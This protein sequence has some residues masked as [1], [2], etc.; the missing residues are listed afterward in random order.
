M[1]ITIEDDPVRVVTLCVSGHATSGEMTA[2]QR[3]LAELMKS[4]PMVAILVRA[5][6]FEGWEGDGWDDM[7]FQLSHDRQ[8]ARIAIVAEPRW[9]EQLL[10]FAGKGLRNFPVRFF[11]VGELGYARAWLTSGGPCETAHVGH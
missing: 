8:I 11:P 4:A 10:V 3:D 7:S 5:E 2:A 9:E 1:S 6:G